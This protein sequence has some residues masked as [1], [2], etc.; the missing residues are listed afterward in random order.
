[1][2]Y[3]ATD[4]N[5]VVTNIQ[6]EF[7]GVLDAHE[8]SMDTVIGNAPF[9]IE[10]ENPTIV[11]VTSSD[12]MINLSD[13]N[14]PILEMDIEFI[15]A[16]D[17]TITPIITFTHSGTPYSTII[18]LMSQ[19][20]WT[21]THIVNAKFYIYA[22]S[23]ERI[24]L[25]LHVTS[26]FD[27]KGNPVE[28]SISTGLIWS[29]MTAPEV[30]SLSSNKAIISDSV[31]GT[32][33]YYIDLSFNEAMDTIAKPLV[34]LS[35]LQSITGSV[36]YNVPASHFLDSFNYRAYFQIID[37]N[38]EIN[39]VQLEID[40]AK[41]HS[42]NNQI[43]YTHSNFTSIDTKNPYIVGI[44]ANDYT[45]DEWGQSFDMMVIY[46][47]PMR[48]DIHP[49]INF[50]PVIPVPFPKLD[51]VWINSTSYSLYHEMQGSPIQTTIFDIAIELGVDLA[52]NVQVPLN[53]IE[54]FQIDPVLGLH[55]T[56][57][58]QVLI[59]PTIVEAQG[60][61]T[62][63]GVSSDENNTEYKLI[64]AI[65]QAVDHLHF[66]KDGEILTATIGNQPSGLYY[67]QNSNHNFKIIMK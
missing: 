28:D 14:S 26:T 53:Q 27:S 44:Y 61:L 50:S 64:N 15:E 30:T 11:A 45:L 22:N 10:T 18:Q 51:S 23:N 63:Q 57:R 46:D 41:D 54:F 40:F 32:S 5:E 37:Q 55:K 49:E 62:I 17:T 9:E 47:E 19:T 35:A 13:L 65:G 59:Y 12:S 42:G 34:S 3:T 48:T 7:S 4:F 16:M 66:V 39:P 2:V 25:D 20:I 56:Y 52:G 67:L 21:D 60:V 24:P 36:Q 6:L 58:D 8:N 33:S 1:M 43:A 31:L 38:I 29:D